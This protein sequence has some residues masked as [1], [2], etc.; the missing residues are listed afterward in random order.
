M[1]RQ[2]LYNIW[3]NMISRCHNENDSRYKWYG[4]KGVI[5][6]DRC[7][8]YNNFVEDVNTRLENGH[9]LYDSAYQ[10]DKDI[11]GGNIYSLENCVVITADANREEKLKKQRKKVLAIKGSEKI[12]FD[13][14]AETADKLNIPVQTIYRYLKSGK[15]HSSGYLFEYFSNTTLQ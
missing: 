8:D 5:V 7:H 4:A 10:L 9:L 13:S 2:S 11:K 14:R 6:C 15:Q 3:Y 12:I 1:E